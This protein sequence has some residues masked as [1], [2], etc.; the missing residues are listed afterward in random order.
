[1]GLGSVICLYLTN[2]KGNQV[3]KFKKKKKKPLIKKNGVFE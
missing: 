2:E 3:S 1:M